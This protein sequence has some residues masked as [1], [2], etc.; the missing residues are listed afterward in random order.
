MTDD[1]T[2]AVSDEDT[3]G[4]PAWLVGEGLATDM[5]GDP[6]TSGPNLR[7]WMPKG[8]DRKIVF[9]TEG[10][11]APVIWEHQ[12]KLGFGKRAWQNWITCTQS[13][14]IKCPVCEWSKRHDEQFR[15]YKGVFFTIIDCAEFEDRAGKKRQNE[16]RLLCAKKDV[17]E[18]LKRKYLQRLEA[19]QGLKGAMFDV[20]RTN[21][22]TS[23]NVGEQFDFVKVVD[24][25]AFPEVD[26]F[27]YA[28]MLQPNLEKAKVAIAQL[29]GDED[30]ESSKGES[31]AVPY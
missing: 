30:A 8:T 3:S 7:Y 9:L 14:G 15:R 19:D 6:A 27:N 31:D 26:E 29:L 13:L 10:N 20:Y 2:K 22:D 21:K 18:I 23:A 11:T 1:S 24:L 5:T 16:R 12:V 28:E 25:A 4:V 17:A